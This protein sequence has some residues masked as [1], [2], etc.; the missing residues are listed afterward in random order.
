MARC[1]RRC[2]T[3][4]CIGPEPGAGG[5]WRPH[6]RTLIVF[7]VLALLAIGAFAVVKRSADHQASAERARAADQAVGSIRAQLAATRADVRGVVGVFS[8]ARTID[9]FA[10]FAEPALANPALDAVSWA[11]RVTAP[12]R[13]AFESERGFTIS[14][15][16]G[17]GVR[18]AAERATYYPTTFVAPTTADARAIGL[19]LAADPA[20]ADAVK[21]AIAGGT[22]RVT[23]RHGRR[24][25]CRAAG[26]ARLPARRGADDA[27]RARRR[28]DRHRDRHHAAR[29]S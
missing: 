20:V 8:T 16:A 11:P 14:E 13:S 24:R 23:N 10:Q 4:K 28:P 22:G 2:R 25:W 27:G 19:D 18:T 15:Q 7:G 5:G 6:R 26:R 12:M 1:C 3:R 21:A 17:D 9:D 29:R